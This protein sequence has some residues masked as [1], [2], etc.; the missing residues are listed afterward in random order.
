MSAW[1]DEGGVTSPLGFTAGGV[2]AGIKNYGPE[3]RYDVGLLVADRPSVAVGLFT[4]NL[5][6]GAPV[7]ISR[8]HL[9]RGI[10]QAIVI[11]SGCS[12]V[13]LG[14][15][16]LRDAREMTQIAGQR[17]GI[18]ASHVLV[19]STG[20][21]GRPLPLERIRRGIESVAISR[22]GG[23]D[24]SRAIM[25]TDRVFK[26]R[27]LRF[28]VAG[29]TYTLGGTV[30][31][32]GMAAPN[33]ATVLGFLTTDAA[34][35]PTWAQ[36]TLKEI[37]DRSLNMLN[38][39]M[40][41]ST[42]DSLF[43]L[44]NGAA[45][46]DPIGAGHPASQPLKEACL[47]LC[48]ALTKDLARD[49]EGA[50]ALLEVEVLGAQSLEDARR[51]AHTIVSSPLVKSMVT[52]RDPNIGRVLMAVGRSGAAVDPARITIVVNGLAAYTAGAEVDPAG[53]DALRASM[54]AAEVRIS[55]DLKL[56]DQRATAWGCDLTEEYVRINASYTT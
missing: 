52:G 14:E 29:K 40:D 48:T 34:L 47:A 31:G 37:A 19:A 6:C 50:N 2:A 11:N 25:T 12:N 18:D 38:I 46:R 17:L 32:S 56:G 4:K 49:G 43:W 39:D 15:R 42:S 1:I 55:V 54:D 5:I 44:A 30:K 8:E 13:G 23:H 22:E 28:E 20:V 27:A 41:T 3:P 10:A 33:M 51:A 45:G 21:I 7:S 9:Q 24:F 36:T 35:D 16:G 26:R 53:Y